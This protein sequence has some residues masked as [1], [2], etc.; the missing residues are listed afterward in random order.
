M[1]YYFLKEKEIAMVLKK[2]I[3]FFIC[4]FKYIKEKKKVK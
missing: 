1:G 4:L 2:E 3:Y